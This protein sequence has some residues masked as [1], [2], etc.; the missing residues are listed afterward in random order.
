M[1]IRWKEHKSDAEASVNGK[2]LREDAALLQGQISRMLDKGV[3]D[4]TLRFRNVEEIDLSFLQFLMV[5]Q[6]EFNRLKLRLKME[7]SL[8]EELNTLLLNAGLGELL[9][10]DL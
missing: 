7:W 1:I 5:L 2:L 9:I 3:R 8:S 4:I 6:K 10:Q